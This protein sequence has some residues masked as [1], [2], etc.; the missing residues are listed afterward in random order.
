V[1]IYM[2]QRKDGK[3]YKRGQS[4]WSASRRWVDDPQ[5]ASVWTTYQGPAAVLQF[6]KNAKRIDLEIDIEKAKI[7]QPE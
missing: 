4:S 7:P 5:K 1:K 6:N 3:Y 2:V